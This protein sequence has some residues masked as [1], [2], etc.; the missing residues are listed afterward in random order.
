MDILEDLRHWVGP[1]TLVFGSGEP[2]MEPALF[3]ICYRASSLGVATTCISNGTLID[4]KMARRICSSGLKSLHLSLDGMRERTHDAGRGVPG[5]YKKLMEAI[6]VLQD[7]ADRPLIKISTIIAGHNLLELEDLVAWT[8]AQQLSGIAFQP[9]RPKKETEWR[10]FWPKNP[11]EAARVIDRLVALK[12]NGYPILNTEATL[13]GMKRYFYDPDAKY[14][15]FVCRSYT[16]LEIGNEGDV[17]FC[18]NMDP[19]G[20]LRRQSLREILKSRM[21]RERFGE[22]LD[23]KKPCILLNCNSQRGLMQ[24][25]SE[26]MRRLAPI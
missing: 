18:L 23:C 1:F 22:I 3:P 19:I 21:S 8:A 13:E 11:L 7:C 10:K 9:L 17:Y 25:G 16:Q 5:T 6:R 20:N 4:A 26:F 24:R 2:F 15:E 12:R 14:P